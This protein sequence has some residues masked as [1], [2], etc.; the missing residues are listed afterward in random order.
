VDRFPWFSEVSVASRPGEWA[1]SLPQLE[2]EC[3]H[4]RFPDAPKRAHVGSFLELMDAPWTEK[5]VACDTLLCFPRVDDGAVRC[6]LSLALE[7]SAR[8]F[9]ALGNGNA[10]HPQEESRVVPLSDMEDRY[11]SLHPLPDFVGSVPRWEMLAPVR[12]IW[13]ATLGVSADFPVRTCVSETASSFLRAGASSELLPVVASFL[14]E[15][16]MLWDAVEIMGL[17]FRRVLCDWLLPFRYP[18]CSGSSSQPGVPEVQEDGQISA[19]RQGSMP[20]GT[21]PRIHGKNRVLDQFHM[22]MDVSVGFTQ[23]PLP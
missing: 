9:P 19:D 2:L 7:A 15:K 18:N 6:V 12:F 11:G 5:E 4:Q 22:R 8:G 13:D 14:S 10:Y 1:N 3:A 20:R 16:A 17:H 21:T 23:A